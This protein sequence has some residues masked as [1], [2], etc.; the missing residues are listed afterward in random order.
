MKILIE[1][2]IGTTLKKEYDE[3]NRRWSTVGYLAVPYPYPYGFISMTIQEDGDPLDAFLVTYNPSGIVRGNYYDVTVIGMAEYF[4]DG[5]RDYKILVKIP[6]E[7]VKINEEVESRLKGFLLHAFDNNPG[8]KVE[9]N[10]F[11]GIEEAEEEISKCQI[12]KRNYF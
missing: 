1:N 4:E 7:D 5:E 2:P 10:G 8:K 6:R 3:R 11:Y 9:F 12:V